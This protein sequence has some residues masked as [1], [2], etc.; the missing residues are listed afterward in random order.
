MKWRA[1]VTSASAHLAPKGQQ[2][3]HGARV[4]HPQRVARKTDDENNFHVTLP[5]ARCGSESRAPEQYL[6]SLVLLSV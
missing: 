2:G 3:P 6:G 4:S 5:S 1:R